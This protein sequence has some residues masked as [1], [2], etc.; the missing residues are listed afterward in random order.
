MSGEL[1]RMPHRSSLSGRRETV[2]SS[3]ERLSGKPPCILA[4]GGGYLTRNRVSADSLLIAGEATFR[5]RDY[6]MNEPMNI[7]LTEGR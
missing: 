6:S 3:L 7:E 2:G 4:Y 5:R 1:V